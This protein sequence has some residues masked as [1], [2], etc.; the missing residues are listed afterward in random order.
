MTEMR[1]WAPA[2]GRM[3]LESSGRRVRMNK[4]G[5]GWWCLQAPFVRHGTDY[6]FRVD[7]R[8]PFPD[9]RSAWQ[10]QGVHGPSRRVAHSR[11]RWSDDRFRQPSPA[12]AVIYEMHVGTF[13][14]EGTF[15]AAIDRLDHLVDLGITHLELMPVAEFS[16]NRG[17][18]YDGV[19]LYAPHHAY[20]GPEGLKRLVDACHRRKLAV[21][22][23]VVYNHLGPEGNYLRTFG[24][25]FSRRYNT[26]WG[27]A[28][29]LD[30]PESDEVRRFFIDN[31][32]MWLRD[33]HVDG[34]RVDAV[35]AIMDTS[36]VHFLEQLAAEVRQLGVETGRR[37]LLIAESD[38]NDPRVVRPAELGGYGF[39]AQWNEDFHHALHAL[40]TGE[41]GGY[42]QDFE[43]LAD[44]AQVISRG[45]AYDGRYS[46][47][48]RRRHGRPATGLSGHRFV[49]CLQN[50]DQVGNRALGERISHLLSPGRQRI[51]AAL[52][53]T[54]P[55]IPMLFQ[56]QE[57]AAT[58]P[59]LYFTDHRDP[60]LG[61]AV[62]NGRQAEFAAFGWRPDDIPDPQ[63]AETFRRCVLDWREL[64]REP[65][66][67]TVD[68]HRS[69]IKLRRRSA[70]LH[71]GRME[72]TEVRFDE[73]AGWLTMMRGT[74]LVACNLADA[75]R[76]V[77]WPRPGERRV[78]LASGE[79]IVVEE[80][81][82]LLPAE[83]VAVLENRN[84]CKKE[85]SN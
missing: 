8:G 77:P 36:A 39:D 59:F 84:Q 7:G 71:N 3:E 23:D 28:V 49:G 37:F 82:I 21:L 27:E 46:V 26:P 60:E 9:P 56:G 52:V 24:P 85:D 58:T 69:L 66:R 68:W 57:W 12:S 33:Y 31:A 44:L 53:L 10:P 20:G 25:Y 13:T 64:P 1:V 22:L 76:H 42:Y 70:P 65:H 30:G 78:L 14:Q 5:G 15:E 45:F 11:F 40:L 48:R 62:K 80:R 2:A 51:G 19:D 67:Q 50:H 63:A 34:L 74:V 72:R 17:W 83:T 38:L 41:R 29:N 16:G 6:A 79:G 18:G 32:L 55:F 75:S 35:H 54:A 4:V 81:G 43:M 73:A 61:E 47:Y